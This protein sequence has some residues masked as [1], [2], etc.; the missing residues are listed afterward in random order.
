MSDELPS[1]NKNY[2]VLRNIANQ[3]SSQEHSEVPDIDNLL[4]MVE[5]ATAAYRACQSRLKAV[6]EALRQLQEDQEADR[7]E[8]SKADGGEGDGLPF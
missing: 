5:E 2:E 8:P 4:P 7:D 6:E 1:F 3:L